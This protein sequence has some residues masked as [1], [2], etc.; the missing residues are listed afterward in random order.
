MVGAASLPPFN[1]SHWDL[2]PLPEPTVYSFS[3]LPPALS[4]PRPGALSLYSPCLKFCPLF[5]TMFKDSLK[6]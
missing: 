5:S 2:P 3:V 4:S 1:S 6:K